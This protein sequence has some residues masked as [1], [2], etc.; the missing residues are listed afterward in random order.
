MAALLDSEL[1]EYRPLLTPVQKESILNVI[2][3][4]VGPANKISIEQYNKEI[5]EA[6]ARVEAGEL[7][8]QEEVERMSK[9]W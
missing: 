3:S 8:T 4:F 5:D 1:N 9:E 6:V 2:K 7:Y